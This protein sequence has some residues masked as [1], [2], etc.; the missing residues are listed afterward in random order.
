M[1][2][3]NNIVHALYKIASGINNESID[4]TKIRYKEDPIELLSMIL[5]LLEGHTAT[6]L[7]RENMLGTKKGKK[8]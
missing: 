1:A 7:I 8:K 6:N 2:V 5:P 4:T 3:T